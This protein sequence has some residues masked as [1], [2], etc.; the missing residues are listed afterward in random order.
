MRPDS[1]TNC[2]ERLYF[3]KIFVRISQGDELSQTTKRNENEKARNTNVHQ[4]LL[5]R[6]RRQRE[7]TSRLVLTV[8]LDLRNANAGHQQS[9]FDVNV[10]QFGNIDTRYFLYKRKFRLRR[11]KQL[12][13]RTV[14]RFQMRHHGN[15]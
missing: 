7:K 2:T 14:R 10:E 9:A 5:H 11:D 8:E 15:I 13:Q 12:R 3:G 6:L 1:L 4:L